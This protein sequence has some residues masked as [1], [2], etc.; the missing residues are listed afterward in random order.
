MK[1]RLLSLI[2]A[3]SMI[4]AVIC[5][6]VSCTVVKLDTP[7]VTLDGNIARWNLI[8]G[9]TGYEFGVNGVTDELSK[10]TTSYALNDGDT[11]IIRAVGAAGAS[12][13]WSLPIKY[14]KPAGG[15]NDDTPTAT[16][17]A[18]PVITL[19]NSGVASWANDE[20]AIGWI[21]KVNGNEERISENTKQLTEGTTIQVKA[22]GNGTTTSDSDWS[23]AK[24]Y[25]NGGE[26]SHSDIDDNGE[27]DVCYETVIVLIDFYSLNDIHG[28]FCDTNDNPGVDELATWLKQR[29]SVDD[30]VVILSTGDMWQGSAESSL[31]W[32]NLM[33]EWMNEVGV[34]SMS[35]GNH[36]YDWGAKYIRD[37]LAIA[38]FPF[39]AI[40]I[41]DNKTGERVDYA[42]PSIM[43]EESGIQIGIIGAIGDC[44]SSI[45][46]EMVADVNFKVGYELTS[47][48]MAE[49]ERLREAG[50]DVIVYA[51]HDGDETYDSSL[52]NGYVD[53]VF[54]GH[55]HSAYSRVDSYGV[56][57]LQGGGENSGI[58][59]AELAV[60]SVTG[61]V[62]TQKAEVVR[63]S[64]YAASNI[65]DDPGTEAI[66]NKYSNI[67]TKAYATL[68][69]NSINLSDSDIEDIVAELYYKA[70][71]EK[72]GAQYDIVLGGG[73]L[74]TRD[75]YNL[76]AGAINYA[77]LLSLLPFNNQLVLCSI[78]GSNLL[79]RFINSTNS[80]YHS[81]YEVSASSIDRN[82]TYYVVVDT[83]T[84]SYRS[85][86][87]T[88][89]ERYDNSTFARDLFAEYIKD[90][91]LD[92]SGDDDNNNAPSIYP[93][94]DSVNYDLISIPEFISQCMALGQG[95]TSSVKFYVKGKIVREESNFATYGNCTIEDEDGNRLYV[96]GISDSDGNKYKYMDEKPVVGDTVILYGEMMYYYNSGTGELKPELK[97]TVLVAKN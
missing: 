93:S 47:L 21:V 92:L 17:L 61:S 84:S 90:G 27:C 1:K 14:T 31:T 66:E 72:W 96:Y 77:T 39:L 46:G 83:Y 81:Y 59:H 85:N 78:S 63:N 19:D 38:N 8:E 23:A 70:G 6:M 28:K 69:N 33:T 26:H 24:T 82:K 67:I 49:S 68:G 53:I 11:F 88:E 22:L 12:S 87:L 97:S 45:L 95:N 94:C 58:S 57:H 71:L 75:P 76:D 51:I 20:G 36:E 73:F 35:I 52:S 25:L 89:I 56:Y 64:V 74:R 10:T 44:Y 18:T 42:T 32:G 60:N 41:Y 4:F 80:D 15:G 50:A 7:V 13:D 5:G 65:L 16:K 62:S 40:N 55:T 9:A 34:V 30:N 48:V 3:A 37:N 2:L 54:E 43:I 79:N 29:E 91:N 86:N